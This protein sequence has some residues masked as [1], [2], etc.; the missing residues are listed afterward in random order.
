MKTLLVIALLAMLAGTVKADQTWTYAGNAIDYAIGTNPGPIG[1]NP[2]GCALDGTLTLD[3]NDTV[4]SYS[5][6]VGADTLTQFNSTGLLGKDPFAVFNPADNYF[7]WALNLIGA[8]GTVMH[9]QFDGSV[10]DAMDWSSS[11]L[12]VEADPGTWA[13]PLATPEPGTLAVSAIALALFV[14]VYYH[15]TR[16]ESYTCRCK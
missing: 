13:D 14:L 10:S 6:T 4:T 3:A 9:S 2:C 11:G 7:R 8:D 12:F 16:R 5:F 15:S 1:L